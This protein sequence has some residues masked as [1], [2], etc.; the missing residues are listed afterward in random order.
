MVVC[1]DEWVGRREE[2]GRVLKQWGGGV[3]VRVWGWKEFEE[4]GRMFPRGHREPKGGNV[5]SICYTS[6]VSFYFLCLFPIL[7]PAC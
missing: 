3:G 6:G 5:A 7:F 4:L 2:A 1:L